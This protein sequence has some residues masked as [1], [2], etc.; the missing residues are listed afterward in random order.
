MLR[1]TGMEKGFKFSLKF[2]RLQ[3][4]A[5]TLENFFESK[6]SV[7]NLFSFLL[8]PVYKLA[9]ILNISY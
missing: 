5:K 6:T 1:N 9:H 4:R 3:V 7:R 8:S 2:K